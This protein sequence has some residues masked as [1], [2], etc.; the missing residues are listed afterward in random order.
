M[1]H[2]GIFRNLKV[3]GGG[4]IRVIRGTFQVH[5]FK[6]VQKFSMIVSH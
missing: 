1:P 2:S 5:I 6:D 4:A 3:G